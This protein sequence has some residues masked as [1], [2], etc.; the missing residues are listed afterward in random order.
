MLREAFDKTV[1]DPVFL[2]EAAKKKLDINPT[3][4]AEVEALV[5]EV[6]AQPKDVI[7]RLKVLM[8]Q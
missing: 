4:G 1:K 2:A 7:D 6:M 5:K 3:A 8:G